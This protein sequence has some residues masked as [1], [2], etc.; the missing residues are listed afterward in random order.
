MTQDQMDNKAVKPYE[1]PY[2][3]DFS[4]DINTDEL[5]WDRLINEIIGGNVVPVIGAE[6]LVNNCHDIHQTIISQL[7]RK[8]KV[9]GKVT[10]F[11]ELVFHK[12]YPGQIDYVYLYVNSY[13]NQ[14]KLTPSDLLKRLLS[15]RQF[16]FVITTS[17]TPVVETVMRDIWGEDLRVLIFGNNP[18]DIGDIREDIEMRCPTVYYMFGKSCT[19]P[20]GFALTDTDMLNYCSSWLSDGCGKKPVNLVSSLSNKYLLMIGN[21]YNDWLF[22]FIWYSL[23]KDKMGNGML[24][25]DSL[26][27]SFLNFLDRTNV[28]SRNNPSEVVEQ[29]EQRIKR[30]MAEKER[31][32]FNKP[33]FN[34]D[35][36]IS[37]SRRDSKYAEKLYDAFSKLGKKVWFDSYNLAAGSQFMNEIRHAIETALFFVPILSNNVMQERI[38]PH[39]YRKEWETAIEVERGLGRNFIYPFASKGFDFYKARIPERMQM[40]NAAKFDDDTDWDELAKEVVHYMNQMI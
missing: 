37:Y 25:Y 19:S 9:E 24:A 31:S 10:S 13:L 2:D 16:P 4:I 20:H 26:E 34:A 23:R 11:S 28:F 40:H 22:R 35:I 18:M 12:D 15:L 6:M 36:F 3:G 33:E 30:K 7:A 17:F 32:K 27:E 29:I 14:V 1:I 5:N 21:N 38:D 8:L 39:V